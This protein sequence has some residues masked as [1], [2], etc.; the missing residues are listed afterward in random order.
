VNSIFL[1]DD[2]ASWNGIGSYSPVN[3]NFIIFLF[4]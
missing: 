3:L 1:L 4:P 2:I